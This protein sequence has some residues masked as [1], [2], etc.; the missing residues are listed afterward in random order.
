MKL[1]K[2]HLKAGENLGILNDFKHEFAVS[3]EDTIEPICLV[4]QNGTGK[5]RLLQC[6]AEIFYDLDHRFRKGG[7]GDRNYAITFTYELEYELYVE[8]KNIVVRVSKDLPNGKP[9]V[10]QRDGDEWIEPDVSE[11]LLPDRVVGYTSGQNET[12]SWPFLQLRDEYSEA[13]SEAALHGRQKALDEL[14]QLRL[15]MV[16]YNLNLAVMCAIFLTRTREDKDVFDKLA[17]LTRIKN[18][19]SLR[20]VVRLNHQAARRIKG[21]KLTGEH[22]RYI[23]NFKSC[24]T[25][26]NFDKKDEVWTFDF[27]VTD[28][29][30]RALRRYFPS[31]WALF[32]AF[33]RLEMLNHLMV[34]KNIRAAHAKERKRRKVS[35]P[36][37]QPADPEKVFLL[38]EVRFQLTSARD[39]VEYIM[40]SD[41]EHQFAHIFGALLIYR[42]GN[43]LYLLDE[44]ESHFNPLWRI[45]FVQ[46]VNGCLKSEHGRHALLMTTHAPFVISDCRSE[47][48]YVF[49][50]DEDQKTVRILRPNFETYGASFDWL[51]EQIFRVKPPIAKKAL[52]DLDALQQEQD[53]K[54]VED[55]LAR[56]GESLER[57][58]VVEH[59]QKLKMAN[60]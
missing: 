44:P 19:E 14:P 51:L 33:Q 23:A 54:I 27:L 24:A 36:A 56:I 41:G 22:R 10:E 46:F 3:A 4:G 37:P 30:R 6:L 49:E 38:Q 48:V 9:K 58:Y 12:L 13:V 45:E 59:L 40:L 34:D 15:E 8:G 31:T 60:D 52:A 43:T 16:D 35:S 42:G 53:P 32:A 26:W 55:G 2:I 17:E 11:K 18:V 28:E 5:S 47:N 21:V 25:C 7:R 20:F 39:P 1:R 57:F 29:T 50:R